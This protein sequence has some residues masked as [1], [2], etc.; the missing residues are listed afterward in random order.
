MNGEK[1]VAL[2]DVAVGHAVTVSA[3]KLPSS[4]RLRLTEL[5]FGKGAM[6][7]CVGESAFGD[8]RA[9]RSRGRTVALRKRDA[10]NI[11]CTIGEEN[12]EREE[13]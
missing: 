10:I 1:T 4:E 7:R 11:I 6:V 9:Y 12:E 3:L 13:E 5:G 8:P 2:S